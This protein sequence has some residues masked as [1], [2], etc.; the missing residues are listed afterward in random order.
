MQVVT[1]REAINT[2]KNGNRVFIHGAA[3]TP[4]PLVNALVERKQELHDIEIIHL[5]TEGQAPYASLTTDNP[6]RVNSFFVA[7]NLRKA[8]NE[9]NA[10]YIPVFLSEVHL[11]FKKQILSPDVSLLQVSPP[12]S[13]GYCTLGCSVDVALAAFATSKTRIAEVN[14]QAPRTHGAGN[15][16]ISQF[17][18]IVKTDRPLYAMAESAPSE[19]EQKIGQYV[20][21]LIEDG[22]TLQMGIG[23]VPN[24]V[25][26]QLTNHKRLGIHTEMFSDGLIPL[27]EKGVITGEEK[28]SSK[29]KVVACFAMGSDS[30][31]KFIHDN[32]LIS[33]REAS[34]T[35]DTGIIRINPKV[36]AINSAIEIDL[37]GQVCAD[38]IGAFLFSGVGGQMDFMR[39]ASLSDGGKPIIA[40]PSTTSSG[41][42]KIVS[43]LKEG[44]GVTTTRAHI[45]YVVTEFGIA[46]LFGKNLRQRAIELINIA[47]PSHR[48]TLEKQAM[49][50]FKHL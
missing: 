7:S 25:L 17:D 35:N 45:H 42:S 33:M 50:R 21:S 26:S 41:A 29:G 12:D 15:I 6:F 47:H 16:H 44:A 34:F 30:L 2:I 48:E 11:L 9:G 27:I 32:P 38:S 49:Q 14:C 24:A 20:A 37:T 8:V 31:Y 43:F 39:G 1:A 10:D 28:V 3:M 19:T 23:G 22:A 40:M 13:H 18:Y 5:H 36:T 46:Y 4:A